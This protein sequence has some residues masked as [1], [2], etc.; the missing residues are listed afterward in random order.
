MRSTVAGESGWVWRARTPPA[1]SHTRKLELEARPHRLAAHHRQVCYG[2]GSA[3]SCPTS[4][5]SPHGQRRPRLPAAAHAPAAREGH[6]PLPSTCLEAQSLRKS[7][8]EDRTKERVAS[9]SRCH[10]RWEQRRW[11]VHRHFPHRSHTNRLDQRCTLRPR[12]AAQGRLLRPLRCDH[13]HRGAQHHVHASASPCRKKGTV[14]PARQ[15]TSAR[16][17]PQ[18]APTHPG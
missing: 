2:W 10:S 3:G 16:Q 5:R 9:Q 6:D 8:R 15:T 12:W 7:K 14:P 17:A 11:M 1:R 4:S 18:A 13:T